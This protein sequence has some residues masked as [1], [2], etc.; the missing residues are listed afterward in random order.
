[1]YYYMDETW[2][3]AGYSKDKVSKDETVT[4]SREAFLLG[5]SSGL[6]NPSGKGKCLI[7]T[8]IGNENGF[9][10]GGLWTF[11]SKKGGDYHTEMNS[12]SYEKWFANILSKLQ[13]HNVIVIDNA[14][15]I[16]ERKKKSQIRHG[17]N[18]K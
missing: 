5:L 13:E 1:M 6:K 16:P 2:I 8:H 18:L 9:V 12:E 4:S 7:I 17:R 11:E 15:A 3:N 10:E 14:P